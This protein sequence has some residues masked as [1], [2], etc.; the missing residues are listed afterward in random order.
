MDPYDATKGVNYLPISETADIVTVSHDHWDHNA[1]SVISGNPEVVTA[2]NP[3]L[4]NGIQ[5]RGVYAWHD[6]EKGDQRG[7]NTVF[8]FELDGMNICHLGDLGHRLS[9]EQINEIGEVDLLFIPVGGYF[10]ID[11]NVATETCD[12]L[13]PRIVV[14]MHYKTSKLDFPIAGVEGFLE[15]KKNVKKLDSSQIELK[16]DE[17]PRELEIVVLI[18]AM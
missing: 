13:K 17:L 5:F 4:H 18:P 8:C 9:R 3:G 7:N 12:D 15:G 6:D 2:D 11:A 14:P 16:S 1:V 10:T